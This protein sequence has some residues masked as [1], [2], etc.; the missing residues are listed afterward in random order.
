MASL[1]DRPAGGR[2]AD[3]WP[4]ARRNI[5]IPGVPDLT[6][7]L[8][9]TAKSDQD[10]WTLGSQVDAGL[11]FQAGPLDLQPLIGLAYSAFR[12]DPF[13][14]PGA[15]SLD[16]SVRGYDSASPRSRAGLRLAARLPGE[17]DLRWIPAGQ[18]IWSHA[19][20]NSVSHLT[21]G[22]AG[23]PGVFAV[24]PYRGRA[25]S[26]RPPSAS[27]RRSRATPG[28]LRAMTANSAATA[29]PARSRSER[30]CASDRARALP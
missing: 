5:A 20:V 24:D 4:S 25:T 13:N 30:A 23:Q 27:S 17:G 2:S 28:S 10:A 26:W 15:N 21:A 22:L 18:V 14:E 1:I 19:I 6:G 29:S 3:L 8:S 7:A 11:E 12:Q 16:L 9:R